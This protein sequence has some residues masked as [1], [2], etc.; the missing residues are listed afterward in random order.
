MLNGRELGVAVVARA[1]SSRNNGEDSSKVAD[2]RK[3]RAI[4]LSLSSHLVPAYSYSY[5]SMATSC[6]W[7][8]QG[9]YPPIPFFFPVSLISQVE[10][11]LPIWHSSS[12]SPEFITA[13]SATLQE[14]THSSGLTRTTLFHRRVFT[15][16]QPPLH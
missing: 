3:A 12:L 11:F 6:A 8:D 5:I 15:P 13:S 2:M 1:G 10:N 4:R 7:S 16:R 14:M 9:V